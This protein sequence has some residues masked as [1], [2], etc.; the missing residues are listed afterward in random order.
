MKKWQT[1]NGIRIYQVLNGRSN[2][3]LISNEKGN[4]LVDN[5]KDSAYKSLRQ[6]VDSINGKPLKI[7]LIILTHTHYDHCQNTFTISKQDHCKIAM[8]WKEAL[9]A[10]QGFS[11]LPKG[12][13][14]I[15]KIFSDLGNLIGKRR[16]GFRPFTP[17]I[18]IVKDTD[19]IEYGISVL[20][21]EG[22]SK[23]SISV[24]V[25]NEIALVG[26]AMIGTFKNSVFPPFA[27]DLKEL[28]KSW[29]RLL[30]T[31]CVA[32]LPGHGKEIKREL[33]QKEYTKYS[34]KFYPNHKN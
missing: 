11:T 26:D 23:G 3:Y 1:K 10:R 15:A 2:S 16:F 21:T 22:H 7:D 8:S 4:I 13:F 30:E 34:R 32:F 20:Q 5:G 9:F 6:N 19:L 33:L 14:R 31:D 24:I 28:I 27:D 18:L 17:G 12:T 29:G 25:D